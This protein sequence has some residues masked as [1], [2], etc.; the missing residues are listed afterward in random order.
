MEEKLF[1]DQ[2]TGVN[3]CFDSHADD[4]SSVDSKV[5]S[6]KTREVY[7]RSDKPSRRSRSAPSFQAAYT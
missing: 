1:D 3:A 2:E 4:L 6:Y 7:M 5:L